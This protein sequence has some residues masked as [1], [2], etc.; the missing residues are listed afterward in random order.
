MPNLLDALSDSENTIDLQ[1]ENLITPIHEFLEINPEKRLITIPESE[2]LFGVYGENKVEIKYFKCPRIILNDIDLYECY[3]FINYISASGKIG[4]IQADTVVL[5]ETE[6]YIIFTWELTRNVFDENTDADIYF[7]ISAKQYLEDKEPVFF[8][9][10]AKGNLYET[11]YAEEQITEQYADIILQ[12]LAEMDGVKEIATPEAMQAYV[13]N[14][15]KENPSVIGGNEVF[16]IASVSDFAKYENGFDSMTTSGTY[17]IYPKLA[18][19][20]DTYPELFTPKDGYTATVAVMEVGTYEDGSTDALHQF[21]TIYFPVTVNGES[22]L[23]TMTATRINLGEPGMRTWKISK[24]DLSNI[25]IAEYGTTALDEILGSLSSGKSCF[26]NYGNTLMSLISYGSAS[27]QFGCFAMSNARGERAFYTIVTVD[28]S[29]WI[30]P[31]VT[32]YTKTSEISESST[33]DEVP[34][35]LAVQKTWTKLEERIGD[36]EKNSAETIKQAVNDYIDDYIGG[37]VEPKTDDIPKVFFEEAIPQTKDDVVT[38]FRYI[39]KTLDFEGYAEF[40]AQGNSSMKYP[41]KNMTV[42]MYKDAELTEKLK[43][44]FK[45]WGKQRKHVYKAN[46]IDLLHA[47]NVVSARI[48]ADVVKSRSN[49]LELPE[50]YRTSPNQGAVDG[51]PVKVYSQGIYQGRYTLNIPKDA[52]MAN[53]DDELDNHC[54]LCSENYVSG[55]FRASANINESDWTDEIHD[56]VP[57]SIKTR[58]NEVI[59]FIMN[60]TDAEFKAN[61]ENYF[62]VDSLIDYLIFGMVSCGLDAFGKNQLF[63]TYDGLKWI[64]GMY[65]MDST[66]GLYWNGSKFVS[67]SYS[68]TE[69]EDFVSGRQGNLLYIRLV[70]LFHE[71][72][73]ARYEE[74]KNSVLSI[75]NIIN[76]FERF[77]DIASLDLVKED[78]ASTTGS[79]KFTGIPSKDTNNIQQIRKFVVDRYVYCDEYFASLGEESTEKTLSS[80]SAT[81]TG[82]NVEVGTPLSSLTGITVTGTWSDGTTSEIIGYTLTGEIVEGENTITVSYNGLTTTFEVI[83]YVE[84]IPCTSITLDKSSLSFTEEVAQTLTAT[85]TPIDT[86]DAIVWT[87]DDELIATVENGVVTP[88]RNGNCTITATCGNRSAECSVSISGLAEKPWYPFKNGAWT[89]NINNTLVRFEV[90]NG[91]HV[92]YTNPYTNNCTVLISDMTQWGGHNGLL[93]ETYPN[94]SKLFSLKAGDTVRTVVTR[95]ENHTSTSKQVLGLVDVNYKFNNLF[96]DN[97]GDIDNTITISTDT[98]YIGFGYWTRA[99]SNSEVYDFDVEIYVNDVRY[100]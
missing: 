71:E 24:G 40:K 6:N 66:W 70:E 3:I 49:Y 72:I 37:V 69:Y 5:D 12:L 38:K 13:D 65:D 45:G 83:G 18:G 29:G 7:S 31:E 55:C 76:H 84:S 23:E 64:A 33:D 8:T 15:L 77:T 56:T 61:L 14:W 68:R 57:T 20:A 99:S 32:K 100:V 46:W 43:I 73:K 67:A 11:V 53:M 85:V 17:F 96:S 63:Y 16:Y 34:T 79:G 21:M 80:I 39:S 22:T 1:D 41:K 36:I 62:F 86:T 50:L 89:G 10:K 75:P 58:W 28:S 59:S 47:R 78:Y 97:S 98:D 81:Y 95:S 48:W 60:S 91:N 87:S 26:C 88:I 52:W 74:L 51:F 90:S 4:Y 2:Q 94:A 30:K 42:K 92:N 25:F 9:R 35:A 82:G 19:I 44:D 93:P 27:V 54:I